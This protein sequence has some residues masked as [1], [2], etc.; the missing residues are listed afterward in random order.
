MKK[1]ID[2]FT[3]FNELDLLEIRLKYLY[4]V[5]DYFVIVESDTSFNGKNKELIF[6]KNK[7]KFKDYSDKIIYLSI[8]MK[9]FF[10][11]GL[12]SEEAVWEREKYQRNCI[13]DGLRTLNLEQDDLILISDIDEI[14]NKDVLQSIQS[15]NYENVELQ[16]KNSLSIIVKTLSYFLKT[17]FYKLINSSNYKYRYRL[18]FM[19][20][21]LIKRYKPSVSFKMVINYYYINYQKTDEIWHGLQCVTPEWLNIFTIDEIRSFRRIPVKSINCGWH[22]SY[23]GGKEM[24]IYKIK[25]FSH[26]EF[27]IKEILSNE[28]IDYCIENG[29][30]LFD[31]YLNPKK[32]KRQFNTINVNHFPKD[33][34][35]ILTEYKNLIKT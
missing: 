17:V 24:I 25:N 5:V 6:K 9:S 10:D 12:N 11:S 30:C 7:G 22:F 8:K 21:I 19:Y 23:L 15:D 35:K 13:N 4:P 28:Y 14:P 16:Q 20:Y 2:C 18:K 26:Q 34:Q 29:Y 27:N 31:Y 3:F 33:L 32:T 1:T